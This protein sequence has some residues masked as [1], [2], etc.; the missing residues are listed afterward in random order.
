MNLLVSCDERQQDVSH[1]AAMF[2]RFEENVY[3][4]LIEKG[5]TFE[6]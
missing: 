1:R 6:I 2:Y 4:R 5:F 3:N